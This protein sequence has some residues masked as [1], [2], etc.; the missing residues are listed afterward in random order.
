[1]G[2]AEIVLAKVLVVAHGVSTEPRVRLRKERRAGR[3]P[4]HRPIDVVGHSTHH[5]VGVILPY[6]AYVLGTLIVFLALAAAMWK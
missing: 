6:V 3:V 2:E 1:M 5:A 4:R